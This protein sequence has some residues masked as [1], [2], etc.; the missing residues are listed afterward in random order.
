M[1][2]NLAVFSLA[3]MTLPA[4]S[5]D[6]VVRLPFGKTKDGQQVER[7]TLNNPNGMKVQ[8]ITFGATLQGIEVPDSKGQF[9]DV[10]VGF[11]TLEGFLGEHPYFG[12]VIGRVCNRIGNAKFSL[13][14]KEFPLAANNGI[15]TLHGGKKGF[16]RQVWAAKSFTHRTSRGVI[17]S[18][19]SPDGEEGFPGNLKVNVTYTLDNDNGLRIDYNAVTDKATPVNLTNHAYFNLAGKGSILGHMLSLNAKS[20]TPTGDTLIP[21]GKLAPVQGTPLD[22]RKPTA[23]GA[24]IKQIEAKPVGYDHN[25]ALE[26]SCKGLKAP[27]A[28]LSDSSSGRVMQVFTTEPGIQFYSGNFLD[29]MV[30]GKKGAAYNQYD[31]LCLETQ[32]FP[33]S[34]NQPSFPSTV[35]KPGQTFTSTTLYRFS[36]EK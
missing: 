27:A 7:F 17:F 13:D 8:V 31:G 1:K 11:D 16:D 28:V 9:A 22:F 15:N 3:I 19:T 20:Y 23:V 35:L 14:G 33:D 12:G 29:G 30:K 2:W 21:T 5:A 26:E 32:H 6:D 10:V 34:I 18:R 25:Y 4:F 36:A 24:R